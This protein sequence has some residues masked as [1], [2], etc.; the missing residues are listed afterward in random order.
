MAAIKTHDK[1]SLAKGADYYAKTDKDEILELCANNLITF[2][3]LF[4]PEDFTNKSKSP[5]FHYQITDLMLDRSKRRVAMVIPRGF[6]KSI[7]CKCA[8]LHRVLFSPKDS[9]QFLAWVAEEQSQAIDHIKYIKYH[10]EYNDAIKYYFG[11][12]AGDAVGNR[13]TEKDFITANG[14]RIMAKGTSQRLRGRSQGNVRYTGIILDDFESELNTKTP[15]RRA[16]IKSWIVST[17]YPALEES[18]GNEG[19]IWL[20]GTIVHYDSFL[21]MVIDGWKSHKDKN[22]YPWSVVFEKAIVDGESIWKDYF[23]MK[24]L[25]AKKQEFIEAG[26][27]NKFAQ[28]YMNDARNSDEAIFKVDRIQHYNST[29]Y[30]EGRYTFLKKDDE[31]TPVNI[32][33][34]VDMAHTAAKTSDYSVIFVLGIDSEKNRYVIDYYRERIPTFDLSEKILQYA[35]LYAPI[36]R[37]VVETVGAQEMVRDMLARMSRAQRFMLPGVAKGIKPPHGIKKE[38]RI[39]GSLASLVNTKRVYIKK[40]HT[41]L[42]DEFFEFPRGRHDDLLDGFYY[43]NY[44]AKS[45]KSSKFKNSQDKPNEAK[46]WVE[47]LE[48]RYNAYTGQRLT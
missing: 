2:G 30:S 17:V 14:H 38:D 13:W 45:P 16:E 32:Y 15:D 9:T 20:A 21:Q 34:G 26:L 27:V 41:E 46:S 25:N 33:I 3:K 22:K 35:K 18:K 39:E 6:G 28:E 42:M 8:L 19:F 5:L 24:K 40:V 43:A 7:L 47:S 4:M 36:K 29:F 23:P 12:M 1:G 31:L 37:V 48:K 10:L 11:N 44:F